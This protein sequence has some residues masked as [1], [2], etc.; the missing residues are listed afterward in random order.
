MLHEGQDKNDRQQLIIEVK[1]KDG[2]RNQEK[3]QEDIQKLIYFTKNNENGNFEAGL[4][5]AVNTTNEE[6][7][8]EMNKFFLNFKP[9]DTDKIICLGTESNEFFAFNSLWRKS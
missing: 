4:F 5:I 6:L 7:K 9:T 3:P 1:T 2:L 8:I